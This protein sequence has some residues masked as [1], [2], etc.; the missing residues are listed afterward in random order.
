MTFKELINLINSKISESE[1]TRKEIKDF[2][3]YGSMATIDSYR[4]QLTNAGYLKTIS[5]GNYKIIKEIPCDL[6]INKLLYEA[7][8]I[9]TIKK[10]KRIKL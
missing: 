8:G 1:I 6:T 10:N 9:S 3:N 5:P 2:L 7:Y 4:C